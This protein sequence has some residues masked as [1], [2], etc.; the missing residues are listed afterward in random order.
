MSEPKP[1]PAAQNIDHIGI[2]V[3]SIDAA[4]ETYQSILGVSVE[5]SSN[6]PERGLEIAFASVGNSRIELLAPIHDRSEVSSF[7][8]KRGEGVHHICF[9]VADIE[10]SVAELKKRGVAIIG[11]E[12][13]MGAHQSKVA[14]VHP[15]TAHGVL[16]ELVEENPEGSAS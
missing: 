5:R 2:A 6:L 11:D 14:F 9:R 8:A 3:H 12:I 4:A 1:S 10:A 15:K 7:L 13:R 16:I